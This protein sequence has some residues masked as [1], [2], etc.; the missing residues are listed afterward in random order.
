MARFKVNRSPRAYTMSDRDS[1]QRFLFENLPVRGEFAQLDT[2]WRSVLE[3]RSY[4]PAIRQILGEAVAATVLLSA[5]IKFDGWL[6]LQIQ[7]RGP[8]R[9]LV[10]QVSS[11]RSLRGLARWDGVPEPATLEHLCGDGTLILTL[12]LGQGRDPYQGVVGLR[13]DSL[14]AT[15]EDYFAQSEQLPTRIQ[16]AANERTSAGLLLQRLP[17]AAHEDTDDWRRLSLL[18]ATLHPRELLELDT[19]TLVGRLFHED[20]VRLFPPQRFRYR[21]NC[22]R[23]RTAAML[24]ALGEAD[25][26]QALA[27]G[28]DLHVDCEFCGH[29]YT[30]DPIDIAGMFTATTLDAP[31][32]RH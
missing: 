2:T 23:E 6:T 20:D 32:T 21:C 5:S 30:F 3:R 7:A 1:L 15:L 22:S 29:R 31:A 14:A 19:A 25:L 8:L 10:V 28:D 18:A 11:D 13:G 26:R 12:D 27:Q 24:H 9:L 16:L 4:P 17:D